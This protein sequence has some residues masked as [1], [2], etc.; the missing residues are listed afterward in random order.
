MSFRQGAT[1][2][3]H[4]GSTGQWSGTDGEAPESGTQPSCGRGRFERSCQ[5]GAQNGRAG[6]RPRRGGKSIAH[7]RRSPGEDTARVSRLNDFR[8]AAGALRGRGAQGRLPG[9]GRGRGPV[10]RGAAGVPWCVT[11]QGRHL[12]T[13]RPNVCAKGDLTFSV[14]T[15]ERDGATCLYS[16]PRCPDVACRGWGHFARRHVQV[17]SESAAGVNTQKGSGMFCLQCENLGSGPGPAGN[18]GS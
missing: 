6:S 18:L 17:E 7:W 4:A 14:P 8:Q 5:R 13:V 10:G 3:V 12:C 11:R 15:G 1:V 16:D 2:C 9:F